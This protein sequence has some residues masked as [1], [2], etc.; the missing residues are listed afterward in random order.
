VAI[1][2][3]P[4][5]VNLQE[6]LM[7][8]GASMQAVTADGQHTSFVSVT[9]SFNQF[10]SIDDFSSIIGWMYKESELYVCITIYN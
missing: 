8:D 7:F 2:T 5:I 10:I 4:V 3:V 6:Y 9:G 1:F